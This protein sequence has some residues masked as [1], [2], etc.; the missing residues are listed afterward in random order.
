MLTAP[1]VFCEFDDLLRGSEI[2][3]A[4]ERR[5]CVFFEE[6]AISGALQ[7]EGHVDPMFPSTFSAASLARARRVAES[8]AT[9]RADSSR[10]SQPHR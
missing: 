4:R 9:H 10:F 6:L 7:K 1:G 3:L 5:A 8:N 2:E